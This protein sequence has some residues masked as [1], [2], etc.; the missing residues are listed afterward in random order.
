MFLRKIAPYIFSIF[1]FAAGIVVGQGLADPSLPFS[2]FGAEPQEE[3]VFDVAVLEEALEILKNRYIRPEELDS[4]GLLWGAIRGM[5]EAETDPYTTFFSPEEAKRFSEDISGHFEGIGAEIGFRNGFL[6]VVAPLKGTPAD[7]AGLQSG[8]VIVS[9]D[10]ESTEKM[11]LEEA[12]LKIRGLAGT[13]VSLLISR[14]GEPPQEIS[15][16]R[17]RIDV[18]PL[19]LRFEDDIAI[20]DLRSFTAETANAMQSAAAE[21]TR[22]NARGIIVDVRNNPGGLLDQAIH[23]SGFF[24]Q[25]DSVVVIERRRGENDM[26]HYSPGPGILSDIPTVVLTNEGTASAAE[27]LAGALR[28]IRNIRLIGTETFGKGS[29]QELIEMRSGARLKITVGEWRTPSGTPL[30]TVGLVP[31]TEVALTPEEREAKRDPQMD[32]AKAVFGNQ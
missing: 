9:V 13:S 26:I 22:R 11:T 5:I 32:A 8:D 27:I 17:A 1:I 3:S 18:A 16:V 21:I 12:V 23:V 29:I 4:A 24:L 15:I 14:Q 28:D 30:G 2:R 31:D 19:E 6:T 7:A 25:Q 10:G 20:I